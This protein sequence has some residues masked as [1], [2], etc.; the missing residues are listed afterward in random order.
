MH[1]VPF[2]QIAVQTQFSDPN[3]MGSEK[4][5]LLCEGWLGVGGHSE[6]SGSQQVIDEHFKIFG[7]CLLTLLDKA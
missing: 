2:K 5:N 4:S 3:R 1:R 6:G 7:E